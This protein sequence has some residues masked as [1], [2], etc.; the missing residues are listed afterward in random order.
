LEITLNDGHANNLG[1]TD[2]AVTS[3]RTLLRVRL[4]A[5]LGIKINENALLS[6]D[7]GSVRE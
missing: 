1:G 4:T 2:D 6:E 7:L 5:L 3:V